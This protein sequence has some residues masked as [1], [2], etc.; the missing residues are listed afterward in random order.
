MKNVKDRLTILFT[1]YVDT[2]WI[3]LSCIICTQYTNRNIFYIVQAFK[4]T[5]VPK[6]EMLRFSNSTIIR[7]IITQNV[8]LKACLGHHSPFPSNR[9]E[10]PNHI[11]TKLN[12]NIIGTGG[13]FDHR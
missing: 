5:T 2:I 11:I 8:Q 6:S 12:N 3:H 9:A 13:V 1:I 4:M 7:R 10:N